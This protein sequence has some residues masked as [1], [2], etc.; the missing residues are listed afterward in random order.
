MTD[1]IDHLRELALTARYPYERELAA[2]VEHCR[3]QGAVCLNLVLIRDGWEIEVGR[4][5]DLPEGVMA[6]AMDEQ[7]VY[8]D[9]AE[10]YPVRPPRP[11]QRIRG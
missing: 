10:R 4:Q 11:P 8:T 6:I 3:K 9:D 1:P 7:W 2:A 5:A